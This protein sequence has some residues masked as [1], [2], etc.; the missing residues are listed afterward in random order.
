[1]AV[2]VHRRAIRESPTFDVAADLPQHG[3][4]ALDRVGPIQ[5]RGEK[6]E[7]EAAPSSING[8]IKHPVEQV[9]VE[10]SRDELGE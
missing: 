10:T 7:A 9:R 6:G 3:H 1:M 8:T 2:A 4:Q 5:L